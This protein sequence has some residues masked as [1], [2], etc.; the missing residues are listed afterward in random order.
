MKHQRFYLKTYGCQMNVHDSERMTGMM[1]ETGLIP[2]N[3]SD[4]ADVVVINTCAVREKPERKLFAELG[5]WKKFKRD[6]PNLIIVVAGCMA[7][8]D[9]DVIRQRAPHVDLLIGPRSIHRLPDLIRK[10]ERQAGRQGRSPAHNYD[11]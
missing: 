6:N 10:V 4:D 5:R 8:R 2:T 9:A 3:D 7:P 1:E 11:A